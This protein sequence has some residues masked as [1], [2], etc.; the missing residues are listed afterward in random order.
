[1]KLAI[2]LL[3]LVIATPAMADGWLCSNKKQD[4]NVK[5]FN[6][7]MPSEGTRVANVMVVSDKSVQTGRKTIVRFTEENGTLKTEGT[8]YIGTVD[9]RFNDSGRKGENVMGTKLG[10]TDTMTL[11]VYFNYTKPAP[12]GDYV[13]A[14][15]VL[16]KRNGSADAVMMMG[17]KRYLKN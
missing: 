9:L 2:A 13:P 1:M 5:V 14:R 6:N 3:A 15:F 4:L 7:V 12:A 10:N 8:K 16:A 11:D 17:C